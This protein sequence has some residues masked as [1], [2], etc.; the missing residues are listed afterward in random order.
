MPV[1]ANS[2]SLIIARNHGQRVP[3]SPTTQVAPD[4][5]VFPLQ[6]LLLG[7]FR[8]AELLDP[9]LRLWRVSSARLVGIARPQDFGGFD[10]M[11]VTM[12]VVGLLTLD[13]LMRFRLELVD[14]R[15]LSLDEAR[16]YV[17][18]VV[19]AS[20]LDDEGKAGLSK[21]I[22]R[23]KSVAAMARAIEDARE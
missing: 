9:D 23:A 13:V 6:W 20:R 7:R 4:T 3:L 15:S 22:Q 19:N 21:R 17:V 16:S 18:E 5:H 2:P 10:S 11:Y 8:N 12:I 14:P 1:G